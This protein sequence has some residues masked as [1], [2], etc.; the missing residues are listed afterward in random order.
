MFQ[1]CAMLPHLNPG[2][3]LGTVL[4]TGRWNRAQAAASCLSLLLAHDGELGL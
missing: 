1:S 2:F 3:R 4:G